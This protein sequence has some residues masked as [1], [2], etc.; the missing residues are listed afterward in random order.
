MTQRSRFGATTL[1]QPRSTG[2][3][4]LRTARQFAMHGVQIWRSGGGESHPEDVDTPV[5]GCLCYKALSEWHLGEIASSRRDHGRVDR[6]S[7]GTE[8]YARI[9]RGTSFCC[10]SSPPRA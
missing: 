3:V 7:E 4:I 9:G 10:A 2:R 8:G 6:T 5:V 1:W